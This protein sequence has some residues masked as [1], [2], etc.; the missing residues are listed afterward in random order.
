MLNLR[1][2]CIENDV[3]K[4]TWPSFVTP[5]ELEQLYCRKKCFGRNMFTIR[6]GIAKFT[7][8]V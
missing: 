3:A 4:K 2:V 5:A 6:Q 7:Q 8:F 1:S